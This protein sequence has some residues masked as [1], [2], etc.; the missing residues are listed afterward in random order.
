MTTATDTVLAALPGKLWVEE[1]GGIVVRRDATGRE[2]LSSNEDRASRSVT[3]AF[4]LA[5]TRPR[6]ERLY[7]YQWRAGADDLFDAGI[8]RPDGTLRPSYAAFAAGCARCRSGPHR[9][10]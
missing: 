6:I 3:A 9:R 7:V 2:L 8:V 5:A 4:A 1:T 10:G